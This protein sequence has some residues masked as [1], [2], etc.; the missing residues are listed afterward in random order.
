LCVA[1]VNGKIYVIG[2][3][4]AHSGS[5]LGMVEVYDPMTDTWDTTK[6]D[7]PTPRKGA[8]CG[9]I[10]NKIY[11]AGGTVGSNWVTSN[12]LEIYDPIT[13]T[14]DITKMNMLA[15]RYYPQGVV[16]NDTF[17]VSGGLIGSPWTGQMAVQKYDPTT[18]NWEFG[19]NLNHGRVGHTTNVIDGKIYAIGGDKQPP[20][21]EI[22]EVYDPQTE[23]WTEIDETPQPIISHTSSVYNNVIYVFSGT[24]KPITQLT[25]TKNVYS[26]TP[27]PSIASIESQKNLTPDVFILHQKYPNTFNPTT[28][29]HYSIPEKSKV[30]LKIFD[31][32]GR[33]IITLVNK[34]QA[35]GN[36]EVEFNAS[37]VNRRITSGVYFY[38]I[39]AGK[40]VETKKMVLMK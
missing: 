10:N 15:A 4:T 38:K 27:P 7:M 28:I 18:D 39:S 3:A 17:Y 29:I 32:L 33:E 11:I 26:Y 21:L 14:W 12:K 31:V 25:L 36:Y 37:S 13:N 5:T 16:V 6:A 40:F 35:Q 1:A 2:G 23:T 34:E 30:T 19:T 20:V 9:V 24:T 8:A 22:V